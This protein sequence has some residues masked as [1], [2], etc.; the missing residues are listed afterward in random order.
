MTISLTN[1]FTNSGTI[2]VADS[3]EI[4]QAIQLSTEGSIVS[5]NLDL[6]ANDFINR[7]L[8]VLRQ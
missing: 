4:K 7:V 5:A 8:L 6:T 2:D 3:F 1:N